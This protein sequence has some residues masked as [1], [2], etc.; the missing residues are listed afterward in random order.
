MLKRTLLLEATWGT[1]H[2]YSIDQKGRDVEAFRGRRQEAG[3]DNC[4]YQGCGL[5][6]LSSDGCFFGVILAYGRERRFLN[7]QRGTQRIKW[8]MK[9]GLRVQNEVGSADTKPGMCGWGTGLWLSS[10]TRLLSPP[11]FLSWSESNLMDHLAAG[12]LGAEK[13]CNRN[14][15]RG[16]FSVVDLTESTVAWEKA[17]WA[18]LWGIILIILIEM[19]TSHYWES[20]FSVWVLDWMKKREGPGPKYSLFSLLLGYELDKISCLG[21]LSLWLP[22]GDGPMS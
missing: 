18:C 7:E 1:E 21:F 5:K 22:Y 11:T 8:H 20:P 16:C 6:A 12:V 4:K 19:G 13:R 15:L 17:L 14:P 9:V 10:T 3:R 2:K